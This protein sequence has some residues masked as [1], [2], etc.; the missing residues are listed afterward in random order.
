MKARASLGLAVT[1]VLTVLVLVPA[2]L[3]A[4][5]A[6]PAPL[7]KP[8]LLDAV[9]RDAD[10]DAIKS[11]GGSYPA[12]GSTTA[13]VNADGELKFIVP[14]GAGRFL[15]FDFS[16]LI[17][18]GEAGF[19]PPKPEDHVVD[20][21]FAT[22]WSSAPSTLN[23][24]SMAPGETKPVRLFFWFTTASGRF[25]MLR[26]NADAPNVGQLIGGDALV[27]AVG[28]QSDGY[29]D[30]WVVEPLPSSNEK[31]QL[32]ERVRVKGKNV[33]HDAGYYRLPFR[34]EFKRLAA[35]GL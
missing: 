15:N 19:E 18:P 12:A 11:D 8:I 22:L 32:F 16:F 14:A 3:Q 10:T 7:V 1:L 6:K 9:F 4:Q 29:A 17:T 28:V 27:T 35:G 24:R 5:R 26:A 30:T 23:F 34:V 13:E 2:I 25:F 21:S 33:Y 31:F 20:W